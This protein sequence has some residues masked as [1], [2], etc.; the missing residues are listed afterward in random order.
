MALRQA[1]VLIGSSAG[2]RPFD[3][4]GAFGNGTK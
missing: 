3:R 4:G 1:A 2:K